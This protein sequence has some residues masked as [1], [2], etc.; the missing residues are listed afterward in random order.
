MRFVLADWHQDGRWTGE[1]DVDPE[2]LRQFRG[3]E[4]RD[5]RRWTVADRNKNLLLDKEEFRA[6][7]HPEHSEHMYGVM[8]DE[9]MQVYLYNRRQDDTRP[10]LIVSGSG[11]GRRREAESGRVRAR[12]A[13]EN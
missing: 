12:N 3:L 9:S 2:T 5:R 10:Y 7:I 1:D 4:D 11:P 8:R 6:F 13:R